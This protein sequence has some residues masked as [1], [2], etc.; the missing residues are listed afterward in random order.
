MTPP[1]SRVLL[2]RA[3]IAFVSA[4]EVAHG[5]EA[6][7]A[8]PTV[9]SGCAVAAGN[10]CLRAWDTCQP[11]MGVCNMVKWAPGGKAWCF[12]GCAQV[13]PRSP[14]DTL[15]MMMKAASVHTHQ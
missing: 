2:L 6:A 12:D 7:C 9:V 5:F 11:V 8:L 13:R 14:N 3:M 1:P 4:A 10:G 15:Y